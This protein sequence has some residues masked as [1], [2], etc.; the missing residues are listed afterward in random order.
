MAGTPR[1]P[2]LT[3]TDADQ[4]VQETLQAGAERGFPPLAVAVIGLAVWRNLWVVVPIAA[5]PTAIPPPMPRWSR[6]GRPP[7]PWGTGA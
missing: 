6:S 5:R 2:G 1:L 4:I 3:L 7:G